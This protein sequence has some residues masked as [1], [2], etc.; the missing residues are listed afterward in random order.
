V[1]NLILKNFRIK[2]LIKYVLVRE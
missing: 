2:K 1:D